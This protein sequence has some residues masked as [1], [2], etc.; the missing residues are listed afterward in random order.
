MID[1]LDRLCSESFFVYND[2]MILYHSGFII[3]MELWYII[4]YQ[5]SLLSDILLRL[6]FLIVSINYVRR[7]STL[8]TI[9]VVSCTRVI[10]SVKYWSLQYKFIINER[11]QWRNKERW[12]KYSIAMRWHRAQSSRNHERKS[13]P[14]IRQRLITIRSE[15]L[16]PFRFYFSVYH[17]AQ[18]ADRVLSR[19]ES[20]DSLKTCTIMQESKTNKS[21]VF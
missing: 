16:K 18:Y 14:I 3:V 4:S 7:H 10:V 9:N 17:S 8:A 13:C 21:T 11:R 2:N 6:I 12:Y 5:L 15:I 1:R 20:A 19:Q